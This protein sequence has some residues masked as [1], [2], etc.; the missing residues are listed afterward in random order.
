M[1]TTTVATIAAHS[2]SLY[3]VLLY[4]CVLSI[5]W[6]NTGHLSVTVLV[7]GLSYMRVANSQAI[8][9]LLTLY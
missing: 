1:R 9:Y 4:L 2:T 8:S 6:Q 5:F 3:C 7:R